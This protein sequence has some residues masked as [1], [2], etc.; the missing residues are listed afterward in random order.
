MWNGTQ[1]T[2]SDDESLR[3]NLGETLRLIA[4]G[5]AGNIPTSLPHRCVKIMSLFSNNFYLQT[6]LQSHRLVIDIVF[7][8]RN[9]NGRLARRERGTGAMLCVQPIAN[10]GRF[11]VLIGESK[12]KRIF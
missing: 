12:L 1:I 5:D 4:A 11:V 2:N 8:A 6:A 10:A 3:V 7:V 9:E